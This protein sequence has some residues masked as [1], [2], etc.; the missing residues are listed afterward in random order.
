MS[1]R[2]PAS[3]K[4]LIPLGIVLVLTACG[5]KNPVAT[6]PIAAKY[7]AEG[8]QPGQIF[9]DRLA[10]GQY[11]PELIV[12]PS[13]RFMLGATGKDRKAPA[14]EKPAHPVV[15]Q[16]TFALTRTEITV[17]DFAEFI[18]SSGYKTQA[19]KAGSSEIFD[20]ASGRLI[21]APGVNWRLDHI[22]KPARGDYPVVHVAFA[23][24]EAY[25]AWLSRRSGHHYRLPSEAEWEYVLRAGTETL[26]PWGDKPKQLGK[27]NLTGSGDLFP[28]GR[29]WRNA[30]QGYSDGYW[31]LAPVRRYSSEGWGTFDMLGNVSEWVADCWH[32]NY[33]RAPANGEAWV[34]AGCSDRVIR[35]S[36]WLSSID[37]SRGSFRM[38]MAGDRT[39]PRL[40]FRLVREL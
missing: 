5:E 9:A 29:N 24:A 39:N 32:E 2:L 10:K 27:G 8:K 34:N 30:I 14:T 11:G 36:A 37:Q 33:R 21:R 35:G 22:G 17:D 6:A 25:A 20:L 15:F 31:A 19:D 1:P 23:D 16:R 4:C 38:R 18:G 7:G 26:F 40:G 28:N 3:M 12:I 13:G